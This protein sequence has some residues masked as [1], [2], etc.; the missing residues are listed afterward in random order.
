VKPIVGTLVG[1]QGSAFALIGHFQ[2]LA[3]QQGADPAELAVVI[4]RATASD[5]ETLVSV[6]DSHLIEPPPQD[7]EV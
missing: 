5:Y 1:V 4:R 7:K 2:K 6:L 3:R